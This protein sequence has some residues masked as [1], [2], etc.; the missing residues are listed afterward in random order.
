MKKLTV[1]E[2]DKLVGKE[3]RIISTAGGH[4]L[5]ID[6]ITTIKRVNHGNPTTYYHTSSS[7]NLKE[8]QFELLPQTKEEITKN[9]KKLKKIYEEQTKKLK[10]KLEYL[11]LSNSETYD[12]NE[13]K[14]YRALKIIDIEKNEFTKAKLIAKLLN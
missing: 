6:S 4:G 9:L 5:A 1:A 13:F 7:T 2:A 12:E 10:D 8:S 11:K 3:V 14:V